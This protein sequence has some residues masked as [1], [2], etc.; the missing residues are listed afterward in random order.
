[1][2]EPHNRAEARHLASELST[3]TLEDQAAKA[4]RHARTIYLPQYIHCPDLG[5]TMEEDGLLWRDWAEILHEERLARGIQ[6]ALPLIEVE[7]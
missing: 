5:K 3:S 1:M 4:D 2:R 6:R 7:L